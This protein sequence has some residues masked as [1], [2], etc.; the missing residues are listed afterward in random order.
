MATTST[1]RYEYPETI[2]TWPPR[3]KCSYERCKPVR[4]YAPK[5]TAGYK[6]LLFH[7]LAVPFFRAVAAILYKHRYGFD[8]MAG[9]SVV[10]R[11]ITGGSNTSLHAHGICFDINPSRNGYRG[12]IGYLDDP[13]TGHK[14]GI[15]QWGRYSDM[16]ALMVR[17]I[18]GIRTNNDKK[19]IEWG[20]RWYNIKDPMHFEL[21]IRK[22]DAKTG[23]NLATVP[24]WGDYLLWLGTEDEMVLKQGDVGNAVRLFQRT[25]NAQGAGQGMAETGTFGPETTEAVRRYQRAANLPETGQIDG[26]TAALLVRYD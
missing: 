7:P 16:P 19:A 3:L 2:L 17:Q 14:E 20:G 18:E 10:C 15:L 11:A 23:V 1:L 21:D 12:A 6:D 5:F 26:V 4:F 8:E 25:L 9:G 13:D 24:G 22:A